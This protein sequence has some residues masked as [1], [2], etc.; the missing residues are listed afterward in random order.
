MP[1]K[2]NSASLSFASAAFSAIGRRALKFSSAPHKAGAVRVAVRVNE[3][4]DLFRGS[5]M[6][7]I[8]LFLERQDSAHHEQRDL[9]T[10]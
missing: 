7:S 5:T 1:V 2:R 9:K 4:L 3:F 6:E 8:W 10:F